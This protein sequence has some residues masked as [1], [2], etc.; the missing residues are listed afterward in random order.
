MPTLRILIALMVA[1]PCA[2]PALGLSGASIEYGFNGSSF[3]AISPMCAINT[4]GEA[5]SASL[6]ANDSCIMAT[7]ANGMN[8]TQIAPGG[9]ECISLEPLCGNVS[10]NSVKITAT[11]A[12]TSVSAAVARSAKITSLPAAGIPQN[13][14]TPQNSGAQPSGA[15]YEIVLILVIVIAA[16]SAWYL[17]KYHYPH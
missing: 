16:V 5:V 10:A 8:A 17:T 2:F 12:G 3:S 6:S 14:S 15:P 4:G 11:L 7:F 1:L 13:A 9:E